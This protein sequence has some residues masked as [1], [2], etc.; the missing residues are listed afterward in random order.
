M[1]GIR[2]SRGRHVLAMGVVLLGALVVASQSACSQVSGLATV[3]NPCLGSP[4]AAGTVVIGPAA[5]GRETKPLK[6]LRVVP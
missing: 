3:L 4:D 2:R 6:L 1:F 5:R